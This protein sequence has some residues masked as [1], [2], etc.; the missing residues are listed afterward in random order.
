MRQRFVALLPSPWRRWGRPA[1]RRAGGAA[2]NAAGRACPPYLSGAAD[3]AA[4]AIR[5]PNPPTPFSKG[6]LQN[7]YRTAL[8]LLLLFG[9]TMLATLAS[10]AATPYKPGELLVKF[11]APLRRASATAERAAVRARAGA[12]VR[13]T[14]PLTGIEVWQMAAAGTDMLA[15][16]KVVAAEPA[17]AYATPNY[18]VR[19]LRLPNDPRFNEQWGLHNTGQSGGVAGVDI[20]APAAW[21]IS[22]G[23]DVV[24]AVTDTGVNYTHPDLISNMWHNPGEVPNDGIDNDLNGYVDDVYGIDTADGDCDPMDDDG[25]G[26]HCAGIIAA[27]GNNAQG[28]AG[29]CWNARIMALDFFDSRGWGEEANGIKCIEYAIQSG[30][31]VISASWGGDPYN[32]AMFDAID[33]ARVSNVL[34][35][36]GAGNDSTDNDIKPF[37]PSSYTNDNIVAVAAST[38]TDALASFSCYGTNSVDLAAPGYEILSTVL[39]SDYGYKNGTSMATPFV[40]GAAAL[41][42]SVQRDLAYPKLKQALLDN[43]DHGPAFAHKLLSGGRLNVYKALLSLLPVVEFDRSAVFTGE[44]TVLTLYDPSLTGAVAHAIALVSSAGDWEPLTLHERS[45]GGFIFTNA[46]PVGLGP[47]VTNNGILEGGDATQLLALHADTLHGGT[48]TG[49]AVIS[50]ALDI[51]I[52]STPLYVALQ[53]QNFN[54][55]GFNNGTVPVQMAVSNAVTGARAAFSATNGWIAPAIALAAGTNTVIVSGTNS[56]GFADAAT[57]VLILC[58]PSGATN[59]VATSGAHV[60]PYLAEAQA[61]TSF[62]AAVAA[63]FHGNLVLAASGSYP[64]VNLLIDKAATFKSSAGAAATILDAGG[65]GRALTFNVPAVMDGFTVQNGTGSNGGGI[66]LGAGTLLNV[67]AVSNRAQANGGGIYCARDAHLSNCTARANRAWR[68][69]GVFLDYGSAA[70]DSSANANVAGDRGGGFYCFYATLAD[71]RSHGNYATNRAGGAY[72]ADGSTVTRCILSNNWTKQ[73]GGGAYCY[74]GMLNN[75]LVCFNTSDSQAG[76]VYAERGCEVNNTLVYGNT[77]KIFGGG[78][79]GKYG[80]V[81]NCT[82]VSNR[83]VSFGGGVFADPLSI[84]NSIIYYNTAPNG[85]NFYATTFDAAACCTTPALTGVP[86]VTNSPQFCAW[87][88]YD[89]R[90]R[91]SSPCRNA[92]NNSY[93]PGTTD[94]AGQLRIVESIVDIGAYEF[95]LGGLQCAFDAVP[96]FGPAP[97]SVTLSAEA[98]GTNVNGLVYAWDFE[99]DGTIDTNGSG[100]AVIEHT[101]TNEQSYA[102]ALSVATSDGATGTYLRT[103][104][105]DAVPEPMLSGMLLLLALCTLRVRIKR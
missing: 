96:A 76:G 65:L 59:Y 44:R 64:V 43:V 94:V 46:M 85:A 8:P 38:P 71:S 5:N 53:Q 14:L 1:A 35:V 82:I 102:V 60:W 13:T 72:C 48:V 63:T 91:A 103:H 24:V 17:I 62:A 99:A 23:N 21:E 92:G 87:E 15:V 58:G 74:G 50:L 61:A 51:T 86:T 40:T 88:Q 49:R 70:Y 69:A 97:L 2:Q 26:S 16:A 11:T 6:G 10:A 19:L 67:V 42:L 22:T 66:Y 34:F 105:I 31:R 90:L 20:D 12:Q 68:G 55:A 100:V 30:A 47:V 52:T 27:V 4:A 3:F 54:V 56:F 18:Y 28:V 7:T 57:V 73:M 25:H 39:F 41:L 98:W 79:Y 104:Y 95:A 93:A 36:A 81:N 29:V 77:S 33:L 9:L 32:Q 101:Y 89:L 37:Y 83:A 80:V 45:A 84:R 75:S 78:I